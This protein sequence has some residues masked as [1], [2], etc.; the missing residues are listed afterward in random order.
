VTAAS[1]AAPAT[2]LAAARAPPRSRIA[3]GAR[4]ADRARW[5]RICR[6]RCGFSALR[7]ADL[8]GSGVALPAWAWLL[9]WRARA[10]LSAARL[11]RRADL[12][13]SAGALRGLAQGVPL[14]PRCGDPRR[15]CGL[16]RGA[17]ELR[18]EYPHAALTGIEAQLAA[19]ARER[20]AL[21]LRARPA[22]RL[23]ER[24]LVALTR[25]STSSSAPKAC[26]R[27]RQ[28]GAR[29]ASRRVAGE[30]RVR[31][32]ATRTGTASS[33][34]ATVAVSGS[35]ARRSGRDD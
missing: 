15:R 30:P 14:A 4:A 25:S 5:R 3:A 35:T 29:A 17:V 18:R 16:G 11:A 26:A 20:G 31:D 22:R 23:L 28:G 13:T 27:A 10:R 34:A 2:P 6:R 8:L 21:P 19:L 24:G 12:P 7:L 1:A 9:R 33:T 32:R